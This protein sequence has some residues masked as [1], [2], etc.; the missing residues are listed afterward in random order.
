MIGEWLVA[1]LCG[2]A[3]GALE[4]PRRVAAGSAPAIAVTPADLE[5]PGTLHFHAAEIV[6][7]G[8]RCAAALH[9]MLDPAPPPGLVP[10][11][12]CGTDQRPGAVHFT[13]VTAA[14]PCPGSWV[15]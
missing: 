9:E 2:V 6:A 1:V 5:I 12:E 7:N 15:R 8:R 3:S 13:S 11:K 14:R 10:C 4:A